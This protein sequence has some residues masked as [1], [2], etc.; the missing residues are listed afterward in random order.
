MASR[1]IRKGPARQKRRENGSG[2][3][4]LVRAMVSPH[5]VEKIGLLARAKD[6]TLGGVVA[7]ILE[8]HFGGWDR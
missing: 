5:I 4:Q 2:Q 6:V 7:G 8:Q 3:R 1:Y